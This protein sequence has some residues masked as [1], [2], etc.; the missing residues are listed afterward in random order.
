MRK[1]FDSILDTLLVIGALACILTIGGGRLMTEGAV[2]EDSG[3]LLGLPVEDRSIDVNQSWY[4][5]YGL[6]DPYQTNSIPVTGLSEQQTTPCPEPTAPAVA[7]AGSASGVQNAAGPL[8]AA[9]CY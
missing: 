6:P 1:V 4:E 9:D 7:A 8:R 3:N 2:V 5:Q